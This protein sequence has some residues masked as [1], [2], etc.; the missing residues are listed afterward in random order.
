MKVYTW[1]GKNS[2]SRTVLVAIGESEYD[3]RQT[4]ITKYGREK[5]EKVFGVNIDDDEPR[6]ILVEGLKSPA[7]GIRITFDNLPNT[8]VI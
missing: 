2:S 1:L 7:G 5:L 8:G 6:F 3:A 4:L